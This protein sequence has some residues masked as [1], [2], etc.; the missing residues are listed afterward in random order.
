LGRDQSQGD[1]GGGRGDGCGEEERAVETSAVAVPVWAV[2][3]A[4]AALDTAAAP[5][6][7]PNSRKV[8]TNDSGGRPG[9]VGVDPAEGGGRCDHAQGAQHRR[10]DAHAGHHGGVAV[11]EDRDEESWLV[12]VLHPVMH[13]AAGEIRAGRLTSERAAG[14]SIATV[15]AAFTSP[16]WPVPEPGA[17]A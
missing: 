17:G 3:L 14:H 9:L 4:A 10:G 1:D 12:N 16:G 5:A 6:E 13:S 7:A 15:L 2:T 11:P 8:L